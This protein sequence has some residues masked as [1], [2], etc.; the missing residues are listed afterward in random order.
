MAAHQHV[1]QVAR[2]RAE[3]EVRESRRGL[4]SEEEARGIGPVRTERHDRPCVAGDIEGE[5]VH[6][7][8]QQR[9]LQVH[10]AGVVAD[11]RARDQ[12]QVQHD[13]H[14][15]Q[16]HPPA[17]GAARQPLGGREDPHGPAQRVARIAPHPREGQQQRGGVDGRIVDLERG[18]GR[19][20]AR[21][22]AHA[23]QD[24]DAERQRFRRAALGGTQHAGAH[25]IGIEQ[26]QQAHDH[27]PGPQQDGGADQRARAGDGTRVASGPC[28]GE[29]R[30]REGRQ[31]HDAELRQAEALQRRGDRPAGGPREDRHMDRQQQREPRPIAAGKPARGGTKR[32]EGHGLRGVTR[33]GRMAQRAARRIMP[34]RLPAPAAPCG[35][36]RYALLFQG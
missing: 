9:N 18:G 30:D 35:Q 1:E 32:R 3:A 22:D 17:F 10:R 29:R 7:L 31:R 26:P 13:R 28:E 24:R 21:P 11:L 14:L 15:Q 5:P 12:E 23:G 36:R 19:Q 34:S 33:A 8:D 6:R 2:Q 20:H 4:A 27:R 25:H 16:R